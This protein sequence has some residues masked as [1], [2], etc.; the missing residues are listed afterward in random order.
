[1]IIFNLKVI[2]RFTKLNTR[3]FARFFRKYKNKKKRKK[4]SLITQFFPPD[5]AA[6]G[7][8]LDELTKR[9]S[10]KYQVNFEIYTGMPFYAFKKGIKANFRIKRK[11]NNVSW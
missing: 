8:L 1:M 2:K 7:Q 10:S 6:T 5:Y 3:I 9:I 11:K 4:I